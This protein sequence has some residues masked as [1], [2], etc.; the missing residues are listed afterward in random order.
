MRKFGRLRIAAL[1]LC[2]AL[3]SSLVF[4]QDR[5]ITGKITD[6]KNLP[7]AGATVL[8]KGTNVVTSTDQTGAFTVTLPQGRRTLVVSY[9][10][11]EQKE[12][13]VGSSDAVSVSLSA[14][15][16]SLTDVVVVGY[17]KAKK[18]N[19]T[20]AQTSVGAKEIEK[21]I[22]TTVEQAIQGRAAG[23]Y[24]TQNSGQPGGGISVNIRGISSI[25]G[26]TQPL[27]VIDGV[28]IQG[29]EV[30]FGAQSSSNALAGL[31]PADIEDIQI[32]QGP[33]ATAIY[34]SRATNGVIL[35]TTKRG[36]SGDAK[37][38][39]VFQ[40]NLQTPP[41]PLKVMNLQQYAQMVKE[42]HAVAGG[43]T[44]GEFL[45]PALLGRGTDW[46]DELFNNAAMMKH[47]L[48][49]SGG[50]GTTT[51]YLSGEYMDQKGVALGSGFKRYGFRL[52]LDNKPRD[53]A[54]VGV[55]LGFN[56]TNEELTTSQENVI[57]NALQ[58]TP[59]IPVKNLNGTWGGGDVTNGAN[60]FAPV[61]PI[62][63]C[64]H[65]NQ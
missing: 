15:G 39:Y 43:T 51:Y 65:D 60:Q 1:L 49:M 45:D 53:W 26:N 28:Q 58:L 50:G 16:A 61:N 25:N 30:S 62:A 8:V 37:L 11:M 47:Q 56:Q 32:L 14:T 40:Y 63:I 18:A 10:G 34:G 13:T 4:A 41:K 20:T 31:N 64:Q 57:S 24:I 35:I 21:T 2:C 54:T 5:K 23:V 19:L 48:S 7:L 44:P 46:Q 33:S 27:Y 29:S 3:Y 36:K 17:G 6:D 55:N 42:F 38:N 22:N 9:V 52:N 59:Q 12:V